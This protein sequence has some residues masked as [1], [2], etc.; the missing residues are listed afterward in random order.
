MSMT[1]LT[2]STFIWFREGLE[3]VAYGPVDQI[4]SSRVDD[5]SDN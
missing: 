4:V 5:D 2:A 1:G 3:A